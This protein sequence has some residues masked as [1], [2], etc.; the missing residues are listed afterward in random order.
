MSDRKYIGSRPATSAIS[1][2]G[3]ISLNQHLQLTQDGVFPEPNYDLP[4]LN[5]T[6]IYLPTSFTRSV[7]TFSNATYT[8]AAAIYLDSG[9]NYLFTASTTTIYRYD[10]PRPG[11]F[12]SIRNIQSQSLLLGFESVITGIYFNPNGTKLFVVGSSKDSILEFNLAVPYDLYTLTYTGRSL[13]INTNSAMKEGAPRS[14]YFTPDGTKIIITAS[15]TAA[16]YFQIDL[17]TAWD[18]TT[19]STYC[20][21]KNILIGTG[22][23]YGHTFST[24]GEY[25]YVTDNVS[26]TVFRYDVDTPWDITTIRDNQYYIGDPETNPAGGAFNSNGTK[27]YYTGTTTD[28][29]Y[30]LELSTPYDINTAT[31]NVNV[32]TYHISRGGSVVASYSF[33]FKPDGTKLYVVDATDSVVEFVL[34]TAWDPA[35]INFSYSFSLSSQE[36]DPRDLFFK[37]D[38]TRMYVTGPVGD[39]VNEY[40]L[41]TAWD[42]STASFVQTFSVGAQETAP[43]SLHFSTDGTKLFVMGQTGD[44]VNEYS[45]GTAWN[46]ST[47]SFV[48]T[49]TLANGMT[50]PQSLTFNS[51]GTAFYVINASTAN[52]GIIKYSLGSAWDLSTAAYDSTEFFATPWA[53]T[54]ARIRFN[55]DGTELFFLRDLTTQIDETILGIPLTSAF[56]I[57]TAQYN[58]GSLF[59]NEATPTGL[60]W[61][62]NG[63]Y[64]YVVGSSGDAVDQFE[65]LVPYKASTIRYLR[66][67]SVA[68]QETVPQSVYLS[69]TGTRMFVLGSTGDDLNQYNLSTAWDISTAQ[70]STVAALSAY[71]TLP[72]GMTFSL[73]GTKL[74]VVGQTNDKIYG[75]ELSTPWELNTLGTQAAYGDPGDVSIAYYDLTPSG[76]AINADGTSLYLV[77]SNQD[78]VNQIDLELPYLLYPKNRF[79]IGNTEATPYSVTFK[80]DGTKMYAIGTTGDSVHEYDLATAWDISTVNN[81]LTPPYRTNYGVTFVQSFSVGAQE[82]APQEIRFKPDGTRMYVMG[83]TGDDIN[84]Y[85]LSTP[86]N[87]SSATFSYSF[88]IVGQDSAPSGFFF[89]SD[90]TR[91]YAIGVNSD[92]VYQYT[93]S[94][95][96]DVSS[97]SYDSVSFSVLPE[98]PTPYSLTVSGDGTRLTILDNTLKRFVSYILETPWD[99][100]SAQLGRLLSSYSATTGGSPYSFTISPDGKTVYGQVYVN[101]STNFIE[102]YE[103]STAYDLKTAQFIR[104]YSLAARNDNITAESTGRF[105]LTHNRT[106]STLRLYTVPNR[107]FTSNNESYSIDSVN[108][109]PRSLNISTKETTIRAF[110]FDPTGT[111]LYISGT[112]SDSVHQYD[113]GTAWNVS[114]ATFVGTFDLVGHVITPVGIKIVED[115]KYLL[116]FCSTHHKINKFELTTPYDVTTAE[117]HSKGRSLLLTKHLGLSRTTRISY[118]SAYFSFD[119]TQL[120]L[121]SDATRDLIMQFNLQDHVNIKAETSR[122]S[123]ESH[124]LYVQ[125]N[126]YSRGS[127]CFSQDGAYLYTL[128]STVNR[129]EQWRLSVPFIA[130]DGIDLLFN[131][132]I[133][134]QETTANGL[135]FNNDGTRFYIVGQTSDAVQEYSLTTPWQLSTAVHSRSFSVSTQTINP[136]GV[137]FNI[138]GTKMFVGDDD[139]NYKIYQYSL[140]TAWDVSTATYDSV[141]LDFGSDVIPVNNQPLDTFTDFVFNGDGTQINLVVA[142]FGE[143]SAFLR[144]NL[145]TAWDLSTATQLDYIEHQTRPEVANGGRSIRNIAFSNQGKMLHFGNQAGYSFFGSQLRTPYDIKSQLQSNFGLLNRLIVLDTTANHAVLSENGSMLLVL[146]G[147]TY[148]YIVSFRLTTPFDL[149]TAIADNGYIDTPLAPTYAYWDATG[150]HLFHSR[151]SLIYEYD[152]SDIN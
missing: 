64:L 27:F 152:L 40:S 47:A 149:N 89:K 119:G 91:M 88:S 24:N 54:N 133:T 45:L 120:Y 102:F 30:E 49:F 111:K 110:T 11:D 3:V 87:V 20:D 23:L 76:L 142:D 68:T 59:G 125:D 37:P 108:F 63:N 117:F 2:S 144:Y 17:A 137:R 48:R 90:G 139:P 38:G 148:E 1:A 18:I 124:P 14:L 62:D 82:T 12:N 31:H 127:F 94:T 10:F 105:L 8:G 69:S 145:A 118:N 9:I 96:W 78:S 115:G 41:S 29:V 58:V 132:D 34:T 121:C 109:N 35:T 93:L 22:N 36:T 150:Q 43:T 70:Y 75:F 25:V 66:T 19:A 72:S 74:F 28:N 141:T 95:A 57:N 71:D 147:S 129:V 21:E 84:E 107:G 86:W 80:P 136:V 135:H 138:D 106:D 73:D 126:I 130:D 104:A 114:T 83:I 143:I 123:W 116:V 13:D 146:G 99:I 39:D 92:R 101:A 55:S 77:G 81:T 26:D 56:N 112:S 15:G 61:G 128:A 50:V 51:S 140:A 53:I 103:L 100:G 122:I 6:S 85:A 60:H 4:F 33:F 42:I 79:Y 46:V 32:K 98:T 5:N 52:N 7:H 16:Y 44:D 97:A 113:L 134:A 65:A 151:G 131:L 67:F